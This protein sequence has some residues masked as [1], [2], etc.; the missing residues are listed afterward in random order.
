M[1]T[2]VTY[3]AA[4]SKPPTMPSSSRLSSTRTKTQYGAKISVKFVFKLKNESNEQTSKL[5]RQLLTAMT[6]L[7]PSVKIFDS[8][9]KQVVP[10]NLTDNNISDHFTYALVKRKFSKSIVVCH[11]ILCPL[12]L[13][14]L[15]KLMSSHLKTNKAALLMNYWTVPDVRDIGWIYGVHPKYH[16]RDSVTDI[17]QNHLQ[18][19][20]HDIPK[21][22]LHT[23][24]ASCGKGKAI[25]KVTAVHVECPAKD[26]QK[27]R[28]LLS[29]AYKSNSLPGQ[30]IPSN[31]SFVRS[32]NAYKNWIDNQQN[33]LNEHRNITISGIS[34]EQMKELMVEYDG[35]KQTL[36][37]VLMS[38]PLVKQV[39]STSKTDSDGLW[40]ISTTSELYNNAKALVDK[41]LD[42]PAKQSQENSQSQTEWYDIDEYND[43]LCN[44]STSTRSTASSTSSSPEPVNIPTN[45]SSKQTSVDS[46][47]SSQSNI[48]R[49]IR[50]EFKEQISRYHSTVLDHIDKLNIGLHNDLEKD[51]EKREAAFRKE[52]AEKIN[53]AIRAS[54]QVAREDCTALI[55]KMRSEIVEQIKIEVQRAIQLISPN[56]RS[57]KQSKTEDGTCDDICQRIFSNTNI[58]SSPPR[59]QKPIV[60]KSPSPTQS[61]NH[62]TSD[63]NEVDDNS[64]KIEFEYTP[65][66]LSEPSIGTP[67]RGIEAPTP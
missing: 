5:H 29:K 50:K 52:A 11:D 38:S 56:P 48:I 17:L 58:P 1:V 45:I 61:S 18:Q 53:L 2:T 57:W 20:E 16:N 6:E 49:E 65:A 44:E 60:N 4:A 59:D 67:P 31:L 13:H 19:K 27:L 10:N 47:L 64:I 39:S 46:P 26:T 9:N 54:L 35:R 55:E 63:E 22:R 51:V 21:F 37:N 3:A 30:F 23:K 14:A 36:G 7:E 33:Y 24:Q 40:N 43:F 62:G 25:V 34:R 42:R 15:R 32:E 28:H 41:V 66:S 8:D 12:P